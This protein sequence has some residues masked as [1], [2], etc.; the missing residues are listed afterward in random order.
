MSERRRVIPACKGD[1][2]NISDC[3][4]CWYC[5]G[6]V[7]GEPVCSYHDGVCDDCRWYHRLNN[8]E[9]ECRRY[10]PRVYLFPELDAV[11]P[12][13]G[14]WPVVRRLDWCGEYEALVNE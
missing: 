8:E 11:E 4:A 13:R 10:V 7:D 14:F 12:L 2:Y 3:F 9:G 5:D 1:D 6:V